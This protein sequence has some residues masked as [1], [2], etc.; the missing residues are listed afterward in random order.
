MGH[1]QYKTAIFRQVNRHKPR[2]HDDALQFPDGQIE[3]LPFLPS[4]QKATVLQLPTS[5]GAKVDQETEPANW[6]LSLTETPAI[7]V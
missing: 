4:C 2:T 5:A 6:Q 7:G 1:D 3:L